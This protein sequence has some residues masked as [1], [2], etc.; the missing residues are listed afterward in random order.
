M[1]SEIGVRAA[2][3]KEAK[4][5]ST[6]GFARVDP[7]KLESKEPPTLWKADVDAAYRRVPVMESQRWT[8]GFA[9]KVNGRVMASTHYATPFRAVGSVN[10]WETL[11]GAIAAIARNVLRIPIL[12]SWTTISP[13]IGQ[14]TQNKP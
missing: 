12:R 5:W 13:R 11:G 1:C 10:S 4:K 7:I 14:P 2:I 6:N 3:K 9:Y 8:T